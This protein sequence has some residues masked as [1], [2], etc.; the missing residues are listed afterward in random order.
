MQDARINHGVAACE[1]DTLPIDL[2]RPRLIS[3]GRKQRTYE[4]V[5]YEN[6]FTLIFCDS[7]GG[8]G[9]GGQC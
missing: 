3:C 9:G 8:G 7:A 1:A 2:P 4:Y 5:K 6:A